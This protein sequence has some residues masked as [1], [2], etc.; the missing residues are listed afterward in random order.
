MEEKMAWFYR[1]I[2]KEIY[3]IFTLPEIDP[4]NSSMVQKAQ[5]FDSVFPYFSERSIP[6]CCLYKNWQVSRISRDKKAAVS[7]S[8]FPHPKMVLRFH[9]S[10]ASCFPIPGSTDVF[11]EFFS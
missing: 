9:K 1:V 7:E 11:R 8:G 3:P 10:S 2:Y 6:Y 4:G 5:L